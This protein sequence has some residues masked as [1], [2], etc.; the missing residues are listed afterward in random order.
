MSTNQEGASQNQSADGQDRRHQKSQGN[1]R[2][3]NDNCY[4]YD[5]RGYHT[6]FCR[7]KPVEGN[8]AMSSKMFNEPDEDLD[9]QVYFGVEECAF[10]CTTDQK[11]ELT[12]TTVNTNFINYNVD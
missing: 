1:Q 7:S 6:K 9:V 4:K 3:R 10:C 8:A 2:W 12:L 5:K 11:D